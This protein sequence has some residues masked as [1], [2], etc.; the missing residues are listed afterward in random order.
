MTRETVAFIQRNVDAA[1]A[2]GQELRRLTLVIDLGPAAEGSNEAPVDYTHHLFA[3][4]LRDDPGM[5]GA[6][7]QSVGRKPNG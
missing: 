5:L 3:D 6:L 7:I 2:R 1:R 4:A